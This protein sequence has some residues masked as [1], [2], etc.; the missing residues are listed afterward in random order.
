QPIRYAYPTFGG[1]RDE[2]A[3]GIMG[4]RIDAFGLLLGSVPKHANS[5]KLI[6]RRIKIIPVLRARVQPPQLCQLLPGIA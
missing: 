6:H 2:K 4:Q 3:V 5:R 1:T